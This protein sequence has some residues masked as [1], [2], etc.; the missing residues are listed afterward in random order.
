MQQTLDI[1][2]QS[3]SLLL[4]K[5]NSAVSNRTLLHCTYTQYKELVETIHKELPG[6]RRTSVGVLSAQTKHTTQIMKDRSKVI[7]A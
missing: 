2:E 6:I 3:V 7:P 1:S 5:F 4:T